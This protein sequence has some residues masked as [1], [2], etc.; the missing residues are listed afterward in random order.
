MLGV[1]GDGGRFILL[2][3]EK[4]K[5]R[6]WERKGCGIG[7][8]RGLADDG[9]RFCDGRCCGVCFSDEKGGGLEEGRLQVT[10]SAFA[11]D[12]VVACVSLIKREEVWRR[13]GS[14]CSWTG[15]V[16]IHFECSF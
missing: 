15:G 10:G 14:K 13:E 2:L 7:L 16:R 12:V 3:G 5:E 8:E 6:A 11:M 9:K 1:D 4:K